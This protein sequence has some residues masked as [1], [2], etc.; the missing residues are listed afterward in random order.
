MTL[1]LA[2]K[3]SEKQVQLLTA[4]VE[5]H[6]QSGTVVIHSEYGPEGT[7]LN[8]NDG[9]GAVRQL[10]VGAEYS[11]IKTLHM[12]GYIISDPEDL[13]TVAVTPLQDAYERARY[14]HGNR[15]TKFLFILWR[16]LLKVMSTAPGAVAAFVAFVAAIMA[17]IDYVSPGVISRFWQAIIP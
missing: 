15:I 17:I 5:V 12:T 4:I 3:L 1:S 7:G 6:K 10:V 16:R 8:V 13:N 11:D 2:Y 14:E 9:T